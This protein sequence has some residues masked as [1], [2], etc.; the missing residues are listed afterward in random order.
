MARGTIA[1]DSLLAL[2]ER[3]RQTFIRRHYDCDVGD[4]THYD[5]MLNT[6]SIT[7]EQ[8]ADVAVP[9]EVKIV[10]EFTE[11]R[12]S[13]RQHRLYFNVVLGTLRLVFL[14]GSRDSFRFVSQG[15][16][17]ACLWGPT[18]KHVMPYRPSP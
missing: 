11:A 15:Q 8:A 7:P 1:A 17:S 9:A 18:V 10:G 5:I 13:L 16:D 4:P 3:E 2:V 14:H 12:E 6:E